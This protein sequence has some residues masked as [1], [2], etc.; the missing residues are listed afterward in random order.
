MN[1]SKRIFR[2]FW[3]VLEGPGLP[4][5]EP[6]CQK[7]AKRLKKLKIKKTHVCKHNFFSNFVRF[8]FPKCNQNQCFFVIFSKMLISRKSCSRR[9]EITIFQARIFQKTIQNRCWDAFEKC[10]E[11]KHWKNRFWPAW[12]G[13]LDDHTASSSPWNGVRGALAGKMH[14]NDRCN[15]REL[16]STWR[17]YCIYIYIYIYLFIYLYIFIYIYI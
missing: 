8:S 9:G 1:A 15:S 3:Q 11:K 2:D 5:I 7:I 4:K 12:D 10:I 17:K 6:K 13:V 16:R 14:W